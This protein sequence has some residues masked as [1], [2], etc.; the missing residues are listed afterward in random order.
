M[1]FGPQDVS[2]T[3]E[4]NKNKISCLKTNQKPS[5][6]VSKTQ[7]S[8]ISNICVTFPNNL[9]CFGMLWHALACH[10]IQEK[11]VLCPECAPAALV[12]C[13][14]PRYFGKTHLFNNIASGF[15][16]ASGGP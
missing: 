10:P 8:Q 11:L 15:S 16:I 2:R 13:R 12:H 3:I 5:Y 9:A 6:K 1:Y 14:R 4:R 7:L